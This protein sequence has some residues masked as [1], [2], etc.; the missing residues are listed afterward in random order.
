MTTKRTGVQKLQNGRFKARYFSGYDSATGKRVYPSRTFDRASDAH[1]WLCEERSARVSRSVEGRG[2]TV[3]AYL[4]HWLSTRL[5]LRENSRDSYRA[6]IEAQIKPSLG[7][8]KLNRLAATHVETWQS[9]LLR[10]VSSTTVSFARSVLYGALESA[11]KKNM[12][13]SNVVAAT[14][15]PKKSKVTRYPLSI[16]DAL[17]FAAACHEGRRLGPLFEIMLTCGLRPEEA[18]GLQWAAIELSPERCVVR[19]ERVIHHLKKGGWR[20]HQPKTLNSE[21]AVVFHGELATRLLDHRKAQLE[22]KLKAGQN[23]QDNDLVF[24]DS[25]GAPIQYH[26]MRYHFKETLR[27]ANLPMTI[28]PYDLRHFFVTSSLVAGVDAKT[29]SREAGHHKVAFTLDVY[30]HVLD[31]THEAAASMRAALLKSRR[32]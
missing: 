13:R 10:R 31:E 11:R 27:R 14:E 18:I 9:E 8:L 20:W 28:K 21:R 17:R 5:G 22:K 1:D 7:H 26:A 3:G 19:V 2:L 16:D 32:K 30:G 15:S 4:D 29:V 25:L 24:S 6:V 12:V 23:W